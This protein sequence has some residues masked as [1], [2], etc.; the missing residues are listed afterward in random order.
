MLRKIIAVIFG[1]AAGVTIIALMETL[2]WMLYMAGHE[3][4]L[5]DPSSGATYFSALPDG[6]FY[7]VLISWA[8]GS[9][10]AG[11]VSTLVIRKNNRFPALIAGL[12]LMLSG[13]IN[14]IMMPHPAWFI[15][16]GILIFLPFSYIGYKLT[17]KKF[18]QS[19]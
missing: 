12:L 18:S 3:I 7:I 17:G 4:S 16:S 10:T 1:F 6:V 11:M 8:F 19:K 2:G 5:K 14:M 13:I 15:V 9:I